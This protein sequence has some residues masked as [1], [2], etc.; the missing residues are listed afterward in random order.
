M[1]QDTYLVQAYAMS[2]RHTHVS[3]GQ[4][5]TNGHDSWPFCALMRPV[6][7]VAQ[8]SAL[9]RPSMMGI[10]HVV[11]SLNSFIDPHFRA[12]FTILFTHEP[13]APTFQ[14]EFWGANVATKHAAR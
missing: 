6:Y 3:L 14:V 10:A 13:C 2:L 1:V 8:L 5:K 7:R 9:S 11:S 4:V 12:S